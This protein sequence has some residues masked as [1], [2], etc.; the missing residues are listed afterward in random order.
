MQPGE[1]F[2]LEGHDIFVED[3]EKSRSIVVQILLAEDRFVGIVKAS[4]I[5]AGISEEDFKRSWKEILIAA[6]D[7]L[8]RR[9]G[10][11]VTI[12]RGMARIEASAYKIERWSW[13]D[14]PL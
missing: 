12:R 11:E 9:H 14:G 3:D 4:A 8:K 10:I 1:T 13:R 2:Q 7:E 6:E 5:Q